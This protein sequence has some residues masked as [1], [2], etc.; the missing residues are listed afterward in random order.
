MSAPCSVLYAIDMSGTK[1]DKVTITVQE[2]EQAANRAR[3]R[4]QR[5]RKAVDRGEKGVEAEWRA[6]EQEYARAQAAVRVARKQECG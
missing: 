5:F 6:A 3:A 1:E 4:V 2:A